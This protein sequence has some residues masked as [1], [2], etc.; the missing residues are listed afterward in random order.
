MIAELYRVLPS[1][2]GLTWHGVIQVSPRWSRC[3]S[4]VPYYGSILVHCLDGPQFAYRFTQPRTLGLLPLLAVVSDERGCV[5]TGASLCPLLSGH[6]GAERLVILC[7]PFWGSA[8]PV[9]SPA[10][11]RFTA[12]PTAGSQPRPQCTGFRCS[13]TWPALVVFSFSGS[14]QTSGCAA[15]SQCALDS[16]FPDGW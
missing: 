14:G 1:A 10:H 8:T 2:T 15:T 16:R 5:N 4:L 7:S 12:P 6:P 11:S 9:H 3:Q 13:T